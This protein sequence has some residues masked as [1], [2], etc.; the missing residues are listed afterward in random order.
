[1][2]A[3]LVAAAFL[4]N[5]QMMVSREMNPLEPVVLTF[6]EVKSGTR[7]NILSGQAH[8]EGTSR[9]FDPEI[10]KRMPKIIERYGN[11]IS[12][13]YGASFKLDY[14]IGT[15]PTINDTRCSEIATETVTNFMGEEA[16]YLFERTTGGEDMA[17]YLNQIPGLI[18][19]VGAR[20]EEKG[21][22]YP[23]HHPQF[24]IDEDSLVIGTEL[25]VRFA[26]DFLNKY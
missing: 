14:R 5:I 18:A 9:C 1:V 4:L 21:A 23:H 12:A 15:L 24:D 3:T 20:N 22:C 26:V 17:Y 10:Q 25:Y 13:A 11:E 7:F 16:V 19:F 6:G 2:D 8:I